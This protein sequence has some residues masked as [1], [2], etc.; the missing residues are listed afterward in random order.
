MHLAH[1]AGPTLPGTAHQREPAGGGD[2]HRRR[3]PGCRQRELHLAILVENM[4]RE[5]YE[6]QVS[7][8]VPVTRIIE[9][10]VHEPYEQLTVHT[11]EEFIGPQS[12]SLANRLA[13]LTDMDNDGTGNVRMEYWRPPV[14]DRIPVLLPTHNSGNGVTNSRFVEYRPMT[15]ELKHASSQ[16]LWLPKPGWPSP[17]GC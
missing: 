3:V 14:T 8:P 12:E 2:S 9:G 6:F 17:T 1:V 7:R 10:R 5:G 11:R 15:G 13:Q 4:R 16:S